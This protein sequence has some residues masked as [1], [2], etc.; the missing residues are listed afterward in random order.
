MQSREVEAPG[1][2]IALHSEQKYPILFSACASAGQGPHVVERLRRF[3]VGMRV[4]SPW[5]GRFE[6][7]CCVAL[8]D[9]RRFRS[10]S[11]SDQDVPVRGGR[12][13]DRL[14]WVNGSLAG[15]NLL[16]ALTHE[17]APPSSGAPAK[18]TWT[19]A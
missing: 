15:F 14:F 1:P 5:R 2:R 19:T 4:V 12:F 11:L 13:V 9:L 10:R 17:Q 16:P 6:A 8:V 18:V 3:D 7:K